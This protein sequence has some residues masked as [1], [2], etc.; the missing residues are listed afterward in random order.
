MTDKDKDN[1]EAAEALARWFKSQNIGMADSCPVM[2]A[3]LGG[4][5]VMTADNDL[6]C[7][8]A[9]AAFTNDL[10]Q[11]IKVTNLRNRRKK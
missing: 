4:I 1:L 7:V 9:L 2:I 3:L 6:E 10:A 8:G 5:I 11:A